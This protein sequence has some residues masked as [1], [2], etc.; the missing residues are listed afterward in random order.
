VPIWLVLAALMVAVRTRWASCPKASSR[1]AAPATGLCSAW[2]VRT[3]AQ[4]VEQRLRALEVLC[5]E[6]LGEPAVDRGENVMGFGAAALITAEPGEAHCGA[7]F[8]ELRLLLLGGAQGLAIE[9]L[10]GLGMP[11]PQQ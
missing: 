4:L 3:L 8:P 9:L 1:A 11:L 7:Q 6:T 5:V 2:A 10:G